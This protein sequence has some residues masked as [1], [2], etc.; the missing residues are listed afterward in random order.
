MAIERAL[1]EAGYRTVAASDGEEGLRTAL[2][3]SPDLILLDVMLPGL[4]GTSVLSRLKTNP[5]TS[6]IP[7][8]VLTG[9]AGLDEARLKNEGAD[10]FLEKSDLDLEGS[11]DALVG[12]VEKTLAKGLSSSQ[13]KLRPALLRR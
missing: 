2:Q 11:R 13:S 6:S 1:R 5:V 9:L 10:G 12:I 3:R 4:P 7:V 8:I